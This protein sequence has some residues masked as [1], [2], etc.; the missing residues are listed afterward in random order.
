MEQYATYAQSGNYTNAKVFKPPYPQ[1]N[2]PDSI[3]WRTKGAVTSVKNQ[4]DEKTL[5]ANFD[6]LLHNSA[7]HW[8]QLPLYCSDTIFECVTIH[9]K[10]LKG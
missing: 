9:E 6:V 10:S 1:S 3:D 5:H 2:Y 8:V 7:H 4:V